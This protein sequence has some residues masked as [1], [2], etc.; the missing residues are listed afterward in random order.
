MAV[1]EHP[2]YARW[3]QASTLREQRQKFYDAV[4]DKYPSTHLIVVNAKAK[5]DEANAEYDAV[6]RTL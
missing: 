1:Q 6:V 2:Q 5:L 4:K 3:M